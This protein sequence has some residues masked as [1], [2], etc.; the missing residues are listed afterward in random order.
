LSNE[1]IQLVHEGYAVVVLIALLYSPMIF[2]LVKWVIQIRIR[3]REPKYPR[4]M[5]RAFPALVFRLTKR[6][7]LEDYPLY[8]HAR[9]AESWIVWKEIPGLKWFLTKPHPPKARTSRLFRQRK[10]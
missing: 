3:L 6:R 1:L 10:T 4:W 2:A 8:D 7:R 9:T 5:L